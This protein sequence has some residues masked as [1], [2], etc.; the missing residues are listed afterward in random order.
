MLGRKVRAESSLAAKMISRNG[1]RRGPVS[2]L[3]IPC[4]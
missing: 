1:A 2:S 3:L 4:S